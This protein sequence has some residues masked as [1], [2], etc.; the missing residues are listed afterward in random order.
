MS[1][2]TTAHSEARWLAATESLCGLSARPAGPKLR[3]F[4]RRLR[5]K[6]V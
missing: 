4:A 1:G 3:V 6:T 2:T 5:V